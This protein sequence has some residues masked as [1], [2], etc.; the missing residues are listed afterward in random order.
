MLAMSLI[1]LVLCGSL[2]G[3][4]QPLG[5]R[6]WQS[7]QAWWTL[8]RFHQ[9]AADL[10]FHALIELGEEYLHHT[11]QG[12]ILEFAA[13]RVGYGASGPSSARLP[14]D[15][16][17]WARQG[18]GALS[19]SQAVLPDPWTGLQ[20]QAYIL[21][22]RVFPLTHQAQDLDTGLQAVA[23][24]LAAGGGLGPSSPGLTRLYRQYL[25]TPMDQRKV[26]LLKRL[27]RKTLEEDP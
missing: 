11:G 12:D 25:D 7:L 26:F 2:I 18:L 17:Y 1:F 8:R 23:D 10:D 5:A 19:R 6:P 24:R 15:A 3:T 22:E 14:E 4:L 16:L 27:Q 9:A 21:V 20:T 13:Y